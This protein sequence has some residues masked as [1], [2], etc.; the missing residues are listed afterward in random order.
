M[1]KHTVIL[2]EK[3]ISFSIDT[4]GVSVTIRPR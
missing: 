2:M 1:K 3:N 4:S